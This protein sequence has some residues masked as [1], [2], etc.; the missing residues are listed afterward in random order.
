MPAVCVPW[1]LVAVP[2]QVVPHS[3]RYAEVRHGSLSLAGTRRNRE[4]TRALL[5]ARMFRPEFGVGHPF[6]VTPR[7]LLVQSDAVVQVTEREKG[8]GPPVAQGAERAIAGSTCMTVVRDFI[9]VCETGVSHADAW[10]ALL[11]AAGCDGV[12]AGGRLKGSKSY[13]AR[14]AQAL[15]S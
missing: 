5:H 10:S 11:E 4:A 3:L 14:E 15:F 2:P 12:G 13:D 8:V 6:R 7:H 1:P 9:T